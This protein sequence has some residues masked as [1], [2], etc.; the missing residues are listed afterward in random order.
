MCEYSLCDRK[1]EKGEKYVLDSEDKIWHI[2]CYNLFLY[3]DM[4][5]YVGYEIEKRIDELNKNKIIK[6]M[7]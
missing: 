4:S 1:I 5:S 3:R 7:N 2:S 6:I